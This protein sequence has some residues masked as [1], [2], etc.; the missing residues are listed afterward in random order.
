[1][2]E[3]SCI[4]HGSSMMHRLGKEVTLLIILYLA[5]YS[6]EGIF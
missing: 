6:F 4:R 1:M 5:L 2:E 3:E